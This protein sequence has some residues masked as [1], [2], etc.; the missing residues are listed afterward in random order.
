MS[1]PDNENYVFDQPLECV[2]RAI[3]G[4]ERK[5]NIG[6][7]EHVLNILQVKFSNMS[8]DELKNIYRSYCD[9]TDFEII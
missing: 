3:R 7:E 5:R 8:R 9:V 6:S 2:Q 4:L 1:I